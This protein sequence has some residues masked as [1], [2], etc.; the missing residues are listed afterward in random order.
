MVDEH[1]PVNG[2]NAKEVK[3]LLNKV[4]Q[5]ALAAARGPGDDKPVIWKSDDKGWTTQNKASP[6]APNKHVMA[7]GMDFLTRIKKGVQSNNANG[8]SKDGKIGG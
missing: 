5:D 2:F 3:D 1:V 7:N 4:Y 6:W 8:G